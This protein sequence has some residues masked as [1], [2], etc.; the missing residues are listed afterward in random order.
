MAAGLRG[1]DRDRLVAAAGQHHHRIE[2]FLEQLGPVGKAP[3]DARGLPYPVDDRAGQVA[4]RRHLEAVAELPQIVEMH[5]LCDQSAAHDA[6]A[7]SSLSQTARDYTPPPMTGANI[8]VA[9]APA[10][11][12]AFQ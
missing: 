9:R 10:S 5:D 8:A 4:E 1:G 3:A 2:R 6:D 12:A 7:Q 11:F